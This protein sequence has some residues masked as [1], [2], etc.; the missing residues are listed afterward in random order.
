MGEIRS[1]LIDRLKPYFGYAGELD[2]GQRRGLAAQ[3]EALLEFEGDP[4]SDPAV[5]A[6]LDEWAAVQFE[7][8]RLTDWK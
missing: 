3:V 8:G 5:M 4:P 2:E 7:H 6:L 1:E